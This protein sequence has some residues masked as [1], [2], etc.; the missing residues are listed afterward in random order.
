MLGNI[1]W[2]LNGLLT[3]WL[4]LRDVFG[5]MRLF[6]GLLGSLTP[7]QMES[8]QPA[9]AVGEVAAPN[10]E[11]AIQDR[12]L[13]QI[14]SHMNLVEFA[15]FAKA[16]SGGKP[17]Q[18]PAFERQVVIDRSLPAVPVECYEAWLNGDRE[19]QGSRREDYWDCAQN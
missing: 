7:T 12:V 11:E 13:D 6:S 17:V 19:E 16:M 3:L 18:K 5:A 8:V 1:G 15:V 14:A 4:I 2:V 10:E 9:A